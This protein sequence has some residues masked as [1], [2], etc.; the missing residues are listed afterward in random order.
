VTETL[1]LKLDV[2]NEGVD[3]LN[4]FRRDFESGVPLYAVINHAMT[5]VRTHC[6]C[7]TDECLQRTL[8]IAMVAFYSA[9]RSPQTGGEKCR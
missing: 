4:S 8:A 6:K 3:L 2:G 9:K 7:G 5:M 1:T